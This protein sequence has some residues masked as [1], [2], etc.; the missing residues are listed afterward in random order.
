M[1][2][3]STVIDSNTTKSKEIAK[4]FFI[5]KVSATVIIPV[6]IARKYG[7]NQTSHVTVEEAPDGILIKRLDLNRGD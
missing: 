6:D 4:V 3:T 2:A 7:L 1:S 5:N